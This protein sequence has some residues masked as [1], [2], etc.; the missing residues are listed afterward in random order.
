MGVAHQIRIAIIGDLVDA[1]LVLGELLLRQGAHVAVL[2]DSQKQA[3]DLDLPFY[4]NL[5][6][7]NIHNFRNA[8]LLLIAI[9]K[10]DFVYSVTSSFFFHIR[11]WSIVYPLLMRLGWPRY[12]VVCSGSNITERAVERS[13]AGIL[14]RMSLKHSSCIALNNYPH[15]IKNAVILRLNNCVFLPFPYAVNA[16]NASVRILQNHRDDA[17]RVFHP[18]HLDWRQSDPGKLRNSTKGSD[19]FLRAFIRACKSGLKARCLI[20]DHGP[21]RQN[22]RSLIDEM[23]GERFFTWKPHLTRSEYHAELMHCDLVVDQFDV[24]AFGGIAVEAM[25]YGKAVIGF[26]EVNYHSLMYDREIPLVL[27]CTE[28]EIETQLWRCRE[29]EYR[30]SFAEL[31]WAWVR[32]YYDSETVG[33]RYLFCAKTASGPDSA[34]EFG[35]SAGS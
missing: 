28:E 14:E 32:R 7:E 17:I 15:A 27:A 31:G 19:R 13:L 2:R 35:L 8:H 6:K 30:N 21:D 3:P 34:S 1:D 26:V 18:G 22:A 25:A 24:G 29:Q 11:A 4:S 9:R 12:M 10:F 20:I 23:D 5:K 33:N 16:P